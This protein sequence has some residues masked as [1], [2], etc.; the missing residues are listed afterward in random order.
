VELREQTLAAIAI[1]WADEDPIAA[2]RLLLQNTQ[3][4][5]LQHNAAVGILQ[6][7]ASKNI[8]EAEQWASQFP[9]DLQETARV[10]LNRIRDQSRSQ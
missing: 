9:D 6:R 10:Q 5:Q 8:D 4:S 3:P 7:L 2:A 1:I